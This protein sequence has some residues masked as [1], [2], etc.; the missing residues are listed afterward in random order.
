MGEATCWKIGGGGKVAQ[1]TIGPLDVHAWAFD[2]RHGWSIHVDDEDGEVALAYHEVSTP[3]GGGVSLAEM[4]AA[5]LRVLREMLTCT[6][7]VVTEL[8]AQA[9]G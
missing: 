1:V 9:D 6:L 4:Q 5:A 2:V 7:G 8:E 3:D